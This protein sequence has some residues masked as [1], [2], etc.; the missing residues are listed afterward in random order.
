MEKKRIVCYGDSNTWGYN[1]HTGLRF[2]DDIRW[3]QRLT[4][5]LGPSFQVC[6]EG[7]SGRTS[8]FDDPLYEGLNGLTH[9]PPILGSHNPIDL[10]IIMLGTNDC[11]QRFSATGQN[12]A[13]G[14][15]RLVQKAQSLAVWRSKPR[16]LVVAPILIGQEIYSVP[17][18]NEGMGAGCAEKSWQLPA[19]LKATALECQC[20]YLDA[21]AVVTAN[22][23]D[24]MHFDAESNAR[25][26]DYLADWIDQAGL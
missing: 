12:I 3:T 26:C 13:D 19:L 21:N 17:R 5:R 16:V 4:D 25:F 15:R 10:L 8:V 7:L 20:D 11:K 24:Y 23:V 2:P 22:T 1:A 18:I 14:V 6:E 9:L